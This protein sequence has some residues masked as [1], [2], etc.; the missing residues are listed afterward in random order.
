VNQSEIPR[1]ERLRSTLTDIIKLAEQKTVEADPDGRN[2]EQLENDG[3]LPA[4][5]MDA[6]VQ[7]GLL[8]RM[9]EQPTVETQNA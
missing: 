7:L 1:L 5:I 9:L 8:V 6:R 2:I 3:D 4:P